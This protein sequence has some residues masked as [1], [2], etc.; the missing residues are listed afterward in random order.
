MTT[1]AI[2]LPDEAF[3]ALKRPPPEFARRMRLAA[4]MH[5]YSRGEVSMEKAALIA[6]GPCR[7]PRRSLRGNRSF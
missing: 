2:D 4:A 1:V 5:W 6:G 3:S 7:A